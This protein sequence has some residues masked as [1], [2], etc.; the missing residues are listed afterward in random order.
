M[1]Y[2]SIVL[3]TIKGL[4][5]DQDEMAN[6]RLYRILAEYK[7]VKMREKILAIPKS[8]KSCSDN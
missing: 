5:D 7:M 3:N 1:R 2:C 6:K 4:K 8:Y